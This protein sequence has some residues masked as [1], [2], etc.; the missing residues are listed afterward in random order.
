MLCQPQR[1]NEYQQL[2][3]AAHGHQPSTMPISKPHPAQTMVRLSITCHAEQNG[4]A[5]EG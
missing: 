3:D 5:T 2:G 1:Q 4:I